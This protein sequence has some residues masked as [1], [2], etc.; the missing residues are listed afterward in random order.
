M[1]EFSSSLVD[2]VGGVGCHGGGGHRLA[3]AG[4]RFVGLLTEHAAEVGDRGAELRDPGCRESTERET[5]DGRC[6]FV[7][8]ESIQQAA[9]TAR[10]IRMTVVLP[11]SR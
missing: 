11:E 10:G 9:S 4:E 2:L 8:S 1:F 7:E 3:F 6:R 5:G